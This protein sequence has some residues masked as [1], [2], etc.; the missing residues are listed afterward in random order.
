MRAYILFII[1][2]L[3]STVAFAE[4]LILEN[5][6]VTMYGDHYYDTVHLTNSTITA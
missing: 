1:T 4:D 6:S 3:L 5:T 2:I